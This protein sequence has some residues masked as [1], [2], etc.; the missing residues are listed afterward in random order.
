[1]FGVGW[2]KVWVANFEIFKV[3]LLSTLENGPCQVG[4]CRKFSHSAFFH[5]NQFVFRPDV[6]VRVAEGRLPVFLEEMRIGFFFHSDRAGSRVPVADMLG[7]L[8]VLITF[9]AHELTESPVPVVAH[10]IRF[11]RH[12]VHH[13]PLL[14]YF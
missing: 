10:L 12:L 6:E 14:Y 4:H 7:N 9:D 8:V 2:I 5:G 1:M 13:L 11:G 3:G